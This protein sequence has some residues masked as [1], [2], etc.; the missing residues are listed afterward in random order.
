MTNKM[1][2]KVTFKAGH[3]L[4]RPGVIRHYNNFQKNQWQ[5]F[6]W[7]KNQ[8]ENQ[9][10]ELINFAYGNVAYYTKLF[11][12]LGTKPEDIATI[13]DLEKLPI[14]TK[15]TI[16]ENWPDFVPRNITRLNYMTSSTSGS[17]G[18]T[19]QYRVSA[20]AHE[21]DTATL[22]C[23][24][25]YG[26]YQLGDKVAVI[27]GSSLIPTTKSTMRRKVQ[28]FFLN[29][30][31]Y[32]SFEM[33]QENLFKYFNDINR[34]KPSF[35]RGYASSLYL[36]ARFIQDNDL[37][38]AFQPKAAFTTSEKLFDKQR[39]VIEEVLGT[40]VFDNYGLAD[41]GLSAFECSEHRGMHISMENA[42][43]EI[44]DDEDKQIIDK[45][46]KILATSLYNYALPFIRYDTGDLGSMSESVC[47]CGR[48]TPLLK[49][50]SG[51][52][53]EFISTPSGLKIH[54]GFFSQIFRAV[55][56]VSQFQLVQQ[57]P[58]EIIIRIVPDNWQV[59]DEI[60][61][62]GIKN[63]IAIKDSSLRVSIQIVTEEKLEYTKAGK[64]KFIINKLEQA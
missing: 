44:V 21:R 20:E 31:H 23:G 45:E 42:I 25:G 10:R 2:H 15:Q 38:L 27:A 4:K 32:S 26:G 63:I 28:D 17:T 53:R 40:R 24:W 22:Y 36:F 59:R 50:I 5:S 43:M 12:Q 11:D 30:R 60:D 57:K 55:K 14:L 34:W 3:W 19:L 61:I 1:L 54:G 47:T 9:L 51:R 52:I 29:F 35:L 16:K 62:K 13:E 41:G 18:N 58:D 37:R 7:L 64:Y 56:N 49:A 39:E 33:S 48:K 6:E 8:Q 46:G